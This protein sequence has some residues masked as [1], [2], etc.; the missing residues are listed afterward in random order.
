MRQV[1]SILPN[2]SIFTMGAFD[3]H[4][5]IA[6][7][8]TISTDFYLKPEYFEIAKEKIFANTWHFVGDSDQ[9]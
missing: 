9:V 1:F 6:H 3:V 4:P 7:A 2:V 5:D 8:K